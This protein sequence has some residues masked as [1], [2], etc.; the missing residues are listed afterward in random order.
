MPYKNERSPGNSLWHLEDHE[1]VKN[2]K[3]M[4]RTKSSQISHELPVAVNPT[5]GQNRIKYIIAI[6]GSTVI[7]RVQNGFPKAEAALF[8]AAVI[9]IKLHELA[10]FDISYIPS[11]SE[12]RDLELVKTMS[13]V[14]PGPNVVGKKATEDTPKKFFRS[15]VRKGLDFRLAPADHEQRS[16]DHKQRLEIESLLETF[17]AITKA[18]HD[19]EFQCPLEDCKRKIIR[20]TS[21][22][23]CPCTDQEQIYVSDSLR[24]HER[25]YDNTSSDQAF[26]AF[27]LVVE[28]LL[29]VNFIRFFYKNHPLRRFDEIAFVI[30]GPLAIFGM[31]AWLKDHIQSEI[32]RIHNDLI[33]KGHAGI[34]LMGMEKSGE[35]IDHFEELDWHQSDGK[36]QRFA[37]GST[38]IPTTDY[39]YRHIRPN[40]NT[41]KAYGQAV[42]YGRKV[43]YKNQ[44]GQHAVVMTPIVNKIGRKPNS[45]ELDVFPRLGEVLDIVDDLYT[46]LYQDG[47][48]PLVRAHAHAAIPLR[49][50]QQLLAN[51][52]DDGNV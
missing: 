37:N 35:F 47:F 17:L 16:A 38:F 50:G 44:A 8:H 9:L 1:S 29:L 12:L 3:G 20:P 18:G 6:D 26:T 46:H 2:F 36:R 4:I 49:Q 42:Y 51:L 21:D 40:P 33:R 25:F 11:P 32:E 45:T 27:R 19:K 30:D 10:K 39:I 5:R 43:L 13:E 31:P 22:T 28:H 34:L 15:I 14:L 52:F 48:V 41:Q 23:K 7:Q 24:M